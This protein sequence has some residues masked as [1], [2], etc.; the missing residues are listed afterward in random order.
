[1]KVLVDSGV[2]IDWFAD[3]QTL[4]TAALTSFVASKRELLVGDLVLTEVLQGTRNAR[5]FARKQAQLG[6]F[7]Q[8][9]IVDPA[10]AV[11]AARFYQRLRTHGV[12][13]RKTIDTLI[14]ARCILDSIPLL[15]ADRDYDPFVENCGLRSALHLA[16]G[17][18]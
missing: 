14:A 1:V 7:E 17:Q 6:A 4:Q 11:E 15:F 3:R 10:V 18:S 8:V 9:A 12:T 5:D 13:V 2:W 16:P